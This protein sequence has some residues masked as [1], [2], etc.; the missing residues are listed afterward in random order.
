M[1]D[2]YY[3][4]DGALADEIELA[5]NEVGACRVEL[6]VSY[7]NQYSLYC[8]DSGDSLEVG[9]GDDTEYAWGLYAASKGATSVVEFEELLDALYDWEEVEG[10]NFL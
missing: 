1:C 9:C 6:W 3:S 7:H 8:V 2:M 4:D 5:C 10:F